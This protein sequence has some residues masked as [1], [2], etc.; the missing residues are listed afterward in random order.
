MSL[1]DGEPIGCTWS[2]AFSEIAMRAERNLAEQSISTLEI[3]SLQ[4]QELSEFNHNGGKY[5]S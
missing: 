5:P 4:L 3:K 2:Q 1:I